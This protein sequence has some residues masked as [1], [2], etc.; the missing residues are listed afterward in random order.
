MQ[1]HHVWFTYSIINT[2]FPVLSKH[3]CILGIATIESLYCPRSH[4][5]GRHKISNSSETKFHLQPYI[6]GYICTW[7][8]TALAWMNLS[9]SISVWG[10]NHYNYVSVTK[11][12]SHYDKRHGLPF[13]RQPSNGFNLV[14]GAHKIL[15]NFV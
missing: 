4:V 7:P 6:I 2:I 14:H 8:I 11:L 3:I 1:P 12:V 5:S 10:Y 9:Y 15:C 13:I